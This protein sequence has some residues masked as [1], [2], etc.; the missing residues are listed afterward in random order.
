MYRVG[1]TKQRCEVLSLQNSSF[2]AQPE[3]TDFTVN[4]TLS[5]LAGGNLTCRMKCQKCSCQRQWLLNRGP[6]STITSQMFM[7]RR[8]R[9]EREITQMLLGDFTVEG[10]MGQ[11]LIE[12]ITGHKD[13]RTVPLLSLTTCLSE[14][15]DVRIPR[16]Y[17]RKKT[18]LVKWLSDHYYQL[19]PFVE[20]I[21]MTLPPEVPPFPRDGVV[22][23]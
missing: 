22:S 8:M 17:R 4:I 14:L 6:L 20:D 18:L 16:D 5:T 15:I 12:R 21:A 3:L 7:N 13:L 19:L 9:S 23:I 10:S 11:Q 1:E 2:F